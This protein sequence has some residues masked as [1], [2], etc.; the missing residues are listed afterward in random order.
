MAAPARKIAA[1]EPESEWLFKQG[2]LVFGPIPEAMLVDKLERGDLPSDTLVAREGG[3]FSPM[4]ET[5]VFMTHAAKASART[6]VEAQAREEQRKRSRRRMA[7]L[8]A[9]L[10]LGTVASVGAV[11]AVLWAARAHLFEKSYEELADLEIV[12]SPP[13]VALRPDA[14]SLGDEDLEYA[15]DEPAATGGKA[16]PRPS[17]ASRPAGPAGSPMPA[18]K[19][20]LAVE[21]KYDRGAI[22]A[23]V[24]AN[25]AKLFPCLKEQVAREPSFRGEVPFTF[26]VGN[27]GRVVKLWIDRAGYASG[28]LHDCMAE[29]LGQWSFPKFEGERPSVSLSFRVNG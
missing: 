26:T 1:P 6:R 27:Q 13:L 25:Q 3:A 8:A 4:T 29:K 2:D 21:S 11:A 23:V 19:D 5:T 16:A 17:K 14:R 12:A 7:R 10:A 15:E 20:G 22:H 28:P 18:E 24:A 9:L